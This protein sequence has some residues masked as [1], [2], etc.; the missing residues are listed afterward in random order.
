MGARRGGVVRVME[1]GDDFRWEQ[2]GDAVAAGVAGDAH[3]GE[4][5]RVTAVAMSAAGDRMVVGVEGSAGP[6]GAAD[7][8]QTTAYRWQGAPRRVNCN[9]HNYVGWAPTSASGDDTYCAFRGE[10]LQDGEDLLQGQSVRFHLT[11]SL[12]NASVPDDDN[13]AERPIRWFVRY[14]ATDGG[15]GA[16]DLGAWANHW[17]VFRKPLFYLRI[18]RDRALDGSPLVARHASLPGEVPASGYVVTAS[19]PNGP[20][21]VRGMWGYDAVTTIDA[22]AGDR[23]VASNAFGATLNP[24]VTES[25]GWHPVGAPIGGAAAG[26]H[27]GRSVSMSGDGM[28]MA[29]GAPGAD[30]DGDGDDH[31]ASGRVR[32]LRWYARG[33]E[34]ERGAWVAM[35]DP[36]E[37]V[38]A[39]AHAGH[40][41]ALSTDGQ[42]LAVGTTTTTTCATNVDA[43]SPAAVS[44]QFTA[45]GNVYYLDGAT[46]TLSVGPGVTYY[47]T[48]IP[49]G[50]P[51]KVWRPDGDPEC[52]VQQH[53]CPSPH[54][55][56]ANYCTGDAAWTI[57]AGCNH[58]SFS[59][60]CY[61]HGAM[62]ATDRLVLDASCASPSSFLSRS[63]RVFE[64][65][66]A[67]WTQMGAAVAV[68]DGGDG[69]HAVALSA[70]GARLA[71]GVSYPD[72]AHAGYAR[73]HEWNGTA[74]TPM[75][76]AVQ[77]GTGHSGVSAALSAD[78]A[79]LVV[80][81]YD[82][83]A[84]TSDAGAARVYEWAAPNWTRVDDGTIGGDERDRL[85]GA[86][87]I[88]AD[89]RGMAV[90]PRANHTSYVRALPRLPERPAPPPPPTPPGAPPPAFAGG[91]AAAARAIASPLP[92]AT[93]P[94]PLR[95][96]ALPFTVPQ[97][98]P[99][100]PPSPA[101]PPPGAPPPASP[102]PG[103]PPGAPP[104]APPPSAPPDAPPTPPSLP[105][106]PPTPPGHV[107]A[108]AVTLTSV[109]PRLDYLTAAGR[110]AFANDYRQDLALKLGVPLD[111]ISV[112][113]TVDAR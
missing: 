31:D 50:H 100:P 90:T 33:G 52:A 27:S 51:M 12:A 56:D 92:P 101:P 36:I 55:G 3:V 45:S 106:P 42:R 25:V 89:G 113:L 20:W 32:V 73:A 109:V 98:P 38:G 8:G 78:G 58:G 46:A 69:A 41:V 10:L 34:A 76:A 96:P 28:R 71:V 108:H 15:T 17:S 26:D 30:G 94:S 67:A 35:G 5:G 39:H 4:D 48:G 7:S 91:D 18:R 68:A 29:I 110:E 23:C 16:A 43:Q 13:C 83:V 102:S 14:G 103:A 64:W 105:P 81:T 74:W 86:I 84:G 66:G 57:P 107:Y 93:P 59:L 97:A 19:S 9:T 70:D 82:A 22:T 65:S 112:A 60:D 44:A 95:P 75:G 2:R 111:R 72:G 54:P 99:P 6:L 85:G 61:I 21:V 80:G 1:R 62:G 79:R 40:S 37:G 104:D 49:T 63:V 53:S 24:V 77:A 11:P 87:A 88:S 47:F